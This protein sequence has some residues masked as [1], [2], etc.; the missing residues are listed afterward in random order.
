MKPG[1]SKN[2]KQ[3]AHNWTPRYGIGVE[4]SITTLVFILDYFQ[5]KTMRKFFKKWKNYSVN[6]FVFF[7][8]IWEK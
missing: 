1:F 7:A 4:I 8:Q 3:R 2:S 6:I 5:E